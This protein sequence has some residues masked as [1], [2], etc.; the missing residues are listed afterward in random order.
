MSRTQWRLPAGK[1]GG[2]VGEEAGAWKAVE[3]GKIQLHGGPSMLT[4][5]SVTITVSWSW[6]GLETQALDWWLLH[7]S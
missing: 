5:I 4:G 1:L 6:K 7:I 3:G 2:D